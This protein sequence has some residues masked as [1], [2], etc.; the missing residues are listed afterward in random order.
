MAIITF[1]PGG[2]GEA[3]YPIR[4]EGIGTTR[5]EIYPSHHEEATSREDSEPQLQATVGNNRVVSRNAA[6]EWYLGDTKVAEANEDVPGGETA[7]LA[8]RVPYEDL[9]SKG[10]FGEYDLRAELKRTPPSTTF[11]SMTVHGGLAPPGAGPGPG[12]TPDPDPDRNSD[13]D[14]PNTDPSLLPEGIPTLPAVGPL[15]AEQT[16]LAAGV[17]LVALLALAG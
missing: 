1:D 15:T 3:Q 2:G 14:K 12:T 6:V 8:A 9:R 13:E 17:G 4:L 10:L 16:T 11:G 7:T 5:R